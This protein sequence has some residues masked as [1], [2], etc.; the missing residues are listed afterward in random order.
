[1]RRSKQALTIALLPALALIACSQQAEQEGA[2]GE[3]TMSMAMDP[4]EL[5]SAVE[6]LGTEWEA[7]F[8]AGDAAMVAGLYAEDATLLPNDS[9]MVEGR[10]AIQ[11]FWADFIAGAPEGAAVDLQTVA[12]EGAG[13]LAYEIGRVTATANGEVLEQGKYL[14]VLRH[15][16]DGSWKIIA[17]IFNSNESAEM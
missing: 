12:V 1:M 14:V 10:Q 9:D 13:D 2:G 3:M 8:N 16:S 15:Q 17:D 6:S 11:E 7:A 5:R 4:M